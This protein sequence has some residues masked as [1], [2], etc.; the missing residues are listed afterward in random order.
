M[1]PR[2]GVPPELRWRHDDVIG[3]LLE[4]YCMEPRFSCW[5]ALEKHA[6]Q[7]ANGKGRRTGTQ[8][9]GGALGTL[10]T[11]CGVL[12]LIALAGGCCCVFGGGANADGGGR[13][14]KAVVPAL[15]PAVMGLVGGGGPARG[16]YK[17]DHVV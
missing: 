7:R 4:H 6:A 13:L 8:L 17:R 9:S 12:V 2:A 16:K 14:P 3:V 10:G 11:I 5:E 15:P 1:P